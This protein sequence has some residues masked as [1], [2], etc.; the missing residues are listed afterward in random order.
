MLLTR[1]FPSVLIGIVNERNT[2]KR[3]IYHALPNDILVCLVKCVSRINDF[4]Q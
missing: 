2:I 3:M 1:S 4:K